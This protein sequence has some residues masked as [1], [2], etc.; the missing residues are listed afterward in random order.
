MRLPGGRPGL[1]PIGAGLAALM[2][3]CLAV[4]WW[5]YAGQQE[6]C[7]DEEQ[8]VFEE[9]PQ[10]GDR[11]VEPESVSTT[12]SCVIRLETPDPEEEIFAYYSQSLLENG[13]EIDTQPPPYSELTEFTGPEATIP[14][15]VV[16]SGL[17]A[18]RGTYVYQVRYNQ[19]PQSEE[20][21][22]VA[23]VL[24]GREPPE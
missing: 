4:A 20:G 10:Y 24:E 8:A 13:W 2:A 9:F 12:S 19:Q 16:P 23:I 18:L 1:L 6:A 5:G 17:V 15:R 3:L 11:Q 21:R 22:I 7:S 14:A